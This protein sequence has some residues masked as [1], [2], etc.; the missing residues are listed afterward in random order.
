[1]PAPFT[2][3]RLMAVGDIR[4]A[5]EKAGCATN[6]LAGFSGGGAPTLALPF[7]GREYNCGPLGGGGVLLW[8]GGL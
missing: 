1:M 5:A 4:D 7:G 2:L 8:G 6:R 3:L